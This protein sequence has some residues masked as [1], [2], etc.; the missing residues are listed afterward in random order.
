MTL[1][2]TFYFDL[3]IKG[4]WLG[5][6]NALFL[7]S[8]SFHYIIAKIKWNELAVQI[9]DRIKNEHLEIQKYEELNEK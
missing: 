1:L 9:N 8:V 2:L 7:I 6:P 4:I 5:G 3:G